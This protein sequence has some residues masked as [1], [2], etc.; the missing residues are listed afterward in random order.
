MFGVFVDI[1]ECEASNPCNNGGTC[2]NTHRSFICICPAGFENKTGVCEGEN[3]YLQ[4]SSFAD[5]CASHY[6][7]YMYWIEVEENES[8]CRVLCFFLCI[9]DSV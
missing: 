1:D 4:F 6:V 7:L 5:Y 8:A 3:L 2:I 9:V